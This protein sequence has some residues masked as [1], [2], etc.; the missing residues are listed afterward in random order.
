[1]GNNSAKDQEVGD[2]GLVEPITPAIVSSSPDQPGALLLAVQAAPRSA[3]QNKTCSHHT[4]DRKNSLTYGSEHSV[5][6]S[7][8]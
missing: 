5:L 2:G 1:M 7:V 3:M 8:F 6:F 4:L